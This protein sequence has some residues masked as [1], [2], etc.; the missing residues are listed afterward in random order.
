M[1]VELYGTVTA[2][3]VVMAL[4]GSEVAPTTTSAVEDAPWVGSV[5][6]FSGWV[7]YT[8]LW[9]VESCVT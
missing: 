6:V 4:A 2:I 1:V 8:V 3:G 7:R 5:T 9:M